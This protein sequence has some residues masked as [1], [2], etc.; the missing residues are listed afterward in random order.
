ML[1]CVICNSKA[2]LSAAIS[3]CSCPIEA[4]LAVMVYA[5][6]T[7]FLCSAKSSCICNLSASQEAYIAS[8]LDEAASS[9]AFNFVL[10]YLRSARTSCLTFA[11]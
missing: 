5:Y 1:I 10:T 9:T 8:Y 11:P 4:N 7:F 6:A 3:S 2:F